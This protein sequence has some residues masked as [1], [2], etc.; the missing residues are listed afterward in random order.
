MTLSRASASFVAAFRAL[1]AERRE[2]AF[3]PLRTEE[4]QR[5]RA[6]WCESSRDLDL[7]EGTLMVCV[8]DPAIHQRL[9]DLERITAEALR[10][11]INSDQAEV[12]ALVGK[13]RAADQRALDFVRAVTAS[14][15]QRR[16]PWRDR[17]TEL[18]TP[19]R[20]LVDRWS[21]G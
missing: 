4:A 10:A 1:A 18:T 7:A 16:S 13:L 12:D 6:F 2:S 3:F 9:A 8:H 21:R 5:A 14:D 20:T 11:A 19:I 15:R 17:L